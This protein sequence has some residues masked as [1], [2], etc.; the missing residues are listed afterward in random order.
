MR[1]PCPWGF[2]LMRW[3]QL[4]VKDNGVGLP[5]DFDPLKTDSLGLQLINNLVKQIEGS[6]EVKSEDGAEFTVRFREI[7]YKERMTPI[8]TV[9]V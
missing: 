1:Q 8:K 3:F 7:K 5:E 6:F 2:L 4:K 9:T